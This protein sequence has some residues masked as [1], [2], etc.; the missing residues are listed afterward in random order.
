MIDSEVEEIKEQKSV[1]EEAIESY[2]QKYGIVGSIPF[3]LKN[4]H[5]WIKFRFKGNELESEYLGYGFK[6][7]K[8]SE[9]CKVLF[10]EWKFSHLKGEKK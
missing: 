3:Y 4:T 10:E 8:V 1:M 9:L 2:K 7:M 6:K 5:L